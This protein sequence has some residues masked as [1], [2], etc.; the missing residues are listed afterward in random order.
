[1]QHGV[2]PYASVPLPYAARSSQLAALGACCLASLLSLGRKMMAHD[3]WADG[4]CALFPSFC[5]M[6]ELQW[7]QHSEH[8]HPTE[9]PTRS[10]VQKPVDVCRTYL[11]S[12][13]SRAWGI[14]AVLWRRAMS[15]FGAEHASLPLEDLYTRT[16]YVRVRYSSKSTG[17][18]RKL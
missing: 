12:I 5:F 15:L 17:V 9:H 6:R 3:S 2:I 18:L 14:R 13:Y 7:R 11:R 10:E 4:T 16:R 8:R 1:V